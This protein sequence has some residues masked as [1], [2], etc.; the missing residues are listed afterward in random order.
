MAAQSILECNKTVQTFMLWSAFKVQ[1][2]KD[3]NSQTGLIEE[4]TEIQIN[5]TVPS[6]TSSLIGTIRNIDI[7]WT[8]SPLKSVL[9]EPSMS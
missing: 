2:M 4:L 6:Y 3:P 9:Q 1:I 5:D 7:F 8:K